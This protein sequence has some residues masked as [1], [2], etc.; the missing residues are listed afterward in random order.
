MSSLLRSGW[1]PSYWKEVFVVKIPRHWRRMKRRMS[2]GK[3]LV[4]ATE[5]EAIEEYKEGPMEWG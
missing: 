5:D 2:H 3:S 1:R 4:R